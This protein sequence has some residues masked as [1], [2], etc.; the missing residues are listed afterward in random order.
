MMLMTITH[1]WAIARSYW[2]P[3]VQIKLSRKLF[4]KLVSCLGLSIWC[5]PWRPPRGPPPS[6]FGPSVTTSLVAEAVSKDRCPWFNPFTG[7]QLVYPANVATAIGLH[8]GDTALVSVPPTHARSGADGMALGWGMGHA[9]DHLKNTG[10]LYPL[11]RR[12]SWL[13]PVIRSLVPW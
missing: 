7:Q 5:L 12:R 3:N 1:E 8:V 10:P 13:Q 9:M 2:L 11:P 4:L 6:G